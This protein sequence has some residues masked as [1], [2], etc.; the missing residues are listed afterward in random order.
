VALSKVRPF[1]PWRKCLDWEYFLV[2]WKDADHD[3]PILKQA[4]TEYARLQ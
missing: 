3:I 1:T 4:K 2:L